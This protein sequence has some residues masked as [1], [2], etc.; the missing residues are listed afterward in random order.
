M[1]ASKTLFCSSKFPWGRERISTKFIDNLLT[2]SQKVS[3][4]QNHANLS[5]L[6]TAVAHSDKTGSGR[7]I[8][9]AN[10]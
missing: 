2:R 8:L 1:E 6:T 4:A 9:I 5:L 7:P 10:T 3:L